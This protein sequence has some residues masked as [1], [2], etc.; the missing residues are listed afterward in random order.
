VPGNFTI[1]EGL[2]YVNN[3]CMRE[4]TCTFIKINDVETLE[5]G[6]YFI[7]TDMTDRHRRV[8]DLL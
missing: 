6:P 5:V 8:L 3:N 2:I 7:S 4:K 1:I